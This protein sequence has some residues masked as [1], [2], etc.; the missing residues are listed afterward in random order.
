M[1][2]ANDLLSVERPINDR[3]S[4]LI[5]PWM[6]DTRDHSLFMLSPQYIIGACCYLLSFDWSI[7]IHPLLLIG[8]TYSHPFSCID[9]TCVYHIGF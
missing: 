2:H 6:N 7:L 9:H 1:K 5:M 3:I 4:F 8:Y